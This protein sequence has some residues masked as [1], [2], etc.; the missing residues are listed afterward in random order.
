[1]A[2]AG[3][4]PVQVGLI[5]LETPA[6][7]LVPVETAG[8]DAPLAARMRPASLNDVIGQ[9]HLVGPGRPLRVAVERGH[10]SSMVLW[11]P[12]GSGKTTLARALAAAAQ[13]HV[14]YLSGTSD[15]V[16]NLRR[17]VGSAIARRAEGTRTVVLVDEI[18]RWSKSQ[19]DSLL[20]HVE[21]GTIILVGA[22]TENPAFDLIAP[23]RSRLV[24]HEVHPLADGDLRA[25]V[26]RAMADPVRGYG[27]L[28]VSID[29][30]AID[31]LVGQSSGDARLALTALEAAVEAADAAAR[32]ATIGPGE[33]AAAL[34]RRHVRY[35]RAG[36]DH[37]DTISAFI[38]SVR[39]SD[40]D[41]ALFW[42]AKMVRAG[43]DPRFIAR[44]LIIL[45]SEDIGNADPVGLLVA[46]SAADA[47]DRVGLPEAGYALAHATTY[48]ACAP[49][50]NRCAAAWWAALSDVDGGAPLDVPPHLRSRPS[51]GSDAEAYQYPHDHPGAHIAQSYRPD[52]V[53]G[54]YYVPSDRGSEAR[55]GA[56]LDAWRGRGGGGQSP[57]APRT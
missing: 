5:G 29:P 42:L 20:P 17:A 16:A 39:G 41:A 9:D 44:R 45:A 37:H 27:A 6:P 10:L 4:A 12:P 55:V 2:S 8:P 1:M 57:D 32:P 43:E 26:L 47:L 14:E 28:A 7:D 53:I 51:R 3:R 54:E 46:T 15:G 35:D 48:L 40:P 24:I 34:S 19:Q 23:L 33:I 56:R 50:S 36:D 13:A 31:Y 38:K 49:K 30:A 25:I 22:T 11:G 18:H 21:D 52:G